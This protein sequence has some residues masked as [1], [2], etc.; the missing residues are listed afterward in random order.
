MLIGKRSE[1]FLK[2]I[3]AKAKMFEYDIPEELHLKINPLSND[4]VLLA[5]AI[6]GDISEEIWDLKEKPIIIPKEKQLQLYFSSRFF[7]SFFQSF[8]D[9]S[10]NP[11]YII[12][13]AV[14]YYYCDMI[15]NSRVMLKMLSSFNFDFHAI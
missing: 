13:G 8:L 3:R 11:Y 2:S 10:S 6:I 1:Y 5:I 9:E 15:G 14:S 4:L 12:L 7:D